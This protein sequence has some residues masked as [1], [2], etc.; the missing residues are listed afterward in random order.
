MG[1]TSFQP[2]FCRISLLGLWYFPV[3]CI[4]KLW[5]LRLLALPSPHS[6]PCSTREFAVLILLNRDLGVEVVLHGVS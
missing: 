1:L 5:H 2:G 6:V 3:Y 4:L